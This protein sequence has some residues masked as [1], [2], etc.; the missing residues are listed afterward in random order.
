[1]IDENW[2]KLA[3]VKVVDMAKRLFD[4]I[5]SNND[6]KEAWEFAK[7]LKPLFE[8]ASK[9]PQLNRE[10]PELADFYQDIFKKC[11]FIAL[12]LWTPE[13][14]EEL[15]ETSITTIF[16]LPDYF[17]LWERIRVRLLA[18]PEYEERDNFKK[19]LRDALL[20][21]KELL[22]EESLIKGDDKNNRPTV[23]NWLRDY[24]VAVGIEPAT[25]IKRSEYLT[26]NQNVQKLT[27][28]ERQKVEQLIAL[29]EKLK[30]SSLTPEGLE[31]SVLTEAN[32]QLVVFKE[33]K[34]EDAITP[35]VWEVIKQLKEVGVFP[36]MDEGEK[37]KITE[38]YL[39]KEEEVKDKEKQSLK[40]EWGNDA[41]KARDFLFSC[42]L[43]G[44]TSIKPEKAK[45][46]AALSFLAEN[47][48]LA[49]LLNEDSRFKKDFAEFLKKE[50]RSNELP[51][52]N[53]TATAPA[54][55]GRFLC[56]LLEKKLNIDALESPRYGVRLG[57]LMKKAGKPE[58]WDMAYYDMKTKTFKWKN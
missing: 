2:K 24:I 58:Y 43:V 47:N 32:G 20:R 30:L 6:D 21:N 54:V 42:C 8:D 18:I 29:F 44:P 13:E 22:T 41:K 55:V 26:K 17:L 12:H 49:Q 28:E 36:P 37:K 19:R 50:G 1:M 51:S 40:Q 33:G 14:I 23:E 38:E 35:K 45:G 10:D 53:I 31:E 27:P 25:A 16:K 39:V 5:I 57:N 48:A 3:D 4:T 15:F 52:L 11:Q 46:L 9:F 34:F 7:W 56:Y